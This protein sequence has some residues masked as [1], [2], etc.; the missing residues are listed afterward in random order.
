MLSD[1]AIFDNIKN[2][3][4]NNLLLQRAEVITQVGEQAKQATVDAIVNKLPLPEFLKTY[5]VSHI[6]ETSELID[7]NKAMEAISTQITILLLV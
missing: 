3:I 5:I 4:L 7:I 1:T 2:A 6:P